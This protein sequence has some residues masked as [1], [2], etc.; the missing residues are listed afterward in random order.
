MLKYL[1]FLLLAVSVCS[2]DVINI[3]FG[4]SA[5]SGAN[6]QTSFTVPFSPGNSITLTALTPLTTLRQTA[7]GIGIGP[8]QPDEIGLLE[9]LEVSFAPPGNLNNFTVDKL[10]WQTGWF[11]SCLINA[12]CDTGAYQVNGGAWT[13]FTGINASGIATINLGSE[14]ETIRFKSVGLLEGGTSGSDFALKG[15]E[16][17]VPDG[18]MTLMLL[19]G[20]LFGFETLRRKFRA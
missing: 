1:M 7:A 16:V 14:V 17:N 19:G 3:D 18:G 2:A 9:F 20:V 15:M 6:G 5:F 4:G 11:G 10:Y 13:Q 12:D 8:I